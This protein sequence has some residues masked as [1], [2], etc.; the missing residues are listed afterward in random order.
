MRPAGVRSR[1]SLFA[2]LCVP[3]CLPEA[4]PQ[5]LG[6]LL[7][8]PVLL[9]EHLIFIPPTS[10]LVFECLLTTLRSDFGALPWSYVKTKEMVRAECTVGMT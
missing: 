9:L 7:Q 6:F 5:V 8:R 1:R 4:L 3:A 2:R 10:N